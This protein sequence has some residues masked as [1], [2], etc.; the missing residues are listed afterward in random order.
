MFESMNTEAANLPAN[1]SV[2]ANE[3][4]DATSAPEQAETGHDND[5]PAFLSALAQKAPASTEYEDGQLIYVPATLLLDMKSGNLFKRKSSTPEL[6]EDIRANGINST[7]PARPHPTKAGFLELIAGYG[8]RDIALELGIDVPVVIRLVD[9]RTALMMHRN[10]NML[11]SGHSFG[12]EVRLTR[13]WLTLFDSKDTAQSLSGWSV[14]KFNERVEMLKAIPAVLDAL[15]DGH[16]QV[17][18]ALI[19]SS[20]DE[21]VQANTLAKVIDEK[22]TVTELKQRADKVVIP[23]S[24]ATFD[25]TECNTCPRNTARQTDLFDM[26]SVAAACAKSSCFREKTTAELAARKIA[27]EERYG[28]VIFMSEFA[29]SDRTALDEQAVGT[30]QFTSGCKGCTDN[31]VMINDKLG[32]NT[33]QLTENQCVNSTCYTKCVTAQK[34][35]VAA[36]EKA[37]QKAQAKAAKAAAPDTEQGQ[38]ETAEKTE[39]KASKPQKAVV[40]GSYSQPVLEAHQQELRVHSA[41]HLR[42]N[43]VFAEA[44]KAYSLMNVA[45]CPTKSHGKQL[46][47]SLMEKSVEELVKVQ[48]MAIS[49]LLQKTQNVNSVA[50]WSFLTAAAKVTETGESTLTAAWEPQEAAISKYTTVQLE[51]LAKDSG[52]SVAQPEAFKKA[53]AGKKSDLVKFVLDAKANGFDWTHFAPAPYLSELKK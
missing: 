51:L 34:D 6:K 1:L 16:I 37:T 41:N 13:E 31:V 3:E 30:E 52:L 40:V 32:K 11:R 2:F 33:G 25:L 36:L 18:H 45:G 10:E 19:L 47:A 21:E 28:R 38:S 15:D 22:W 46:I 7:V 53:S 42:D 24:L 26:G 39:P 12:D 9:D 23:L 5:T 43:V 48:E 8:R 44:M 17:K 35:A 50:A 29:E 20:F 14:T 4:Q 27:A 49:F